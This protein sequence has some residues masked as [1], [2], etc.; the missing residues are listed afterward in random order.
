MPQ[1]AEKTA[2]AIVTQVRIISDAINWPWAWRESKMLASINFNQFMVTILGSAIGA[3]FSIFGLL[4]IM[5][6][7]ES[8]EQLLEVKQ[9]EL[10]IVIGHSDVISISDDVKVTDPRVRYALFNAEKSSI[11]TIELEADFSLRLL[12]VLDALNPTDELLKLNDLE[13]ESWIGKSILLEP[14]HALASGE[15][16]VMLIPTMF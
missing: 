14:T 15:S 10:C 11:Y 13:G 9:I 8:R 7:K 5:R 16:T 2:G 1:Q 6:N 4:I 12:D 3:I